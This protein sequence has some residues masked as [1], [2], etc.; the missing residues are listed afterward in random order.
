MDDPT[1][2]TIDLTPRDLPPI[3]RAFRHRNYR[4]FFAG[5][6]VSLVGTFL[7]Q[8]A[9]VWFV[10]RLTKSTA[11]MGTVLFFGQLPL[12][13]LGPFA[14]VVADRVASRRNFIVLTQALS[15]VQSAALA[16]VAWR[17]G[18]AGH[19]HA[20]VGWLIGLSVVQGL[21][22]AFDLPARQAFLIEMVPDRADL[23]NAI[24]LNST[25][26]HGARVIGP[27]AAGIIIWKVG[28]AVC[29]SI[30]AVSYVGVIV[31]LLAMAVTARHRPAGRSVGRDLA[32][33]AAY[34]WN[35]RP[36]RTLLLFM[37]L[38][39]LV[40]MQSVGLAMPVFGAYF[41]GGNAADVHGEGARMYGLLGAVSGGG[42]LVGSIY[43]AARSSVLGLGRLI[44][45]AVGVFG[46]GIVAFG[47]STHLWLSLLI[48]PFI[49]WGMITSFA[50]SNTL[51]QTVV[52]DELRGRVMSFFGMAFL[53]VAPF[54]SLLAGFAAEHL[55]PR[56]QLPI[57]G[58]GRTLLIGGGVCCLA[59]LAYLRR[60][61][62]IRAAMRPIYVERGI[63]P[64][65]PAVTDVAD[66]LPTPSP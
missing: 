14:G 36:I 5:Q 47:L 66:P 2:P 28:E 29:F 39:S 15:M 57:V 53:G 22:N 25:M 4:L 30:D 3:L 24:A 21:V 33:G 8:Y 10:Y 41:A 51:I 60:L 61:P 44:A 37:A 62:A 56:G 18:D 23:P 35:F 55:T 32:E 58:S 9:T 48:V 46:L 6:L 42:A 64:A 26:V 65:V 49:G 38:L 7:T 1:T 17:L 40:G 63:L 59:T 31:A 34:V 13:L 19:V 54:G 12:L 27:A 16:W 45:V 20:A 52:P 50:S 11:L 43:L